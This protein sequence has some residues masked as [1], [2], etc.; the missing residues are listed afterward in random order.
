MLN[1]LTSQIDSSWIWANSIGSI[2]F[3]VD[4]AKAIVLYVR[5]NRYKLMG[6]HLNSKIIYP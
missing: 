4:I 3:I 2:I 1:L 5:R 6:V